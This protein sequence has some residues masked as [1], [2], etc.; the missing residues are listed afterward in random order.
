MKIKILGTLFGLVVA[1]AFWFVGSFVLYPAFENQDTG[2]IVMILVCAIGGYT[3][4]N[5]IFYAWMWE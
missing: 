2:L 1:G 5:I 4:G 3:A